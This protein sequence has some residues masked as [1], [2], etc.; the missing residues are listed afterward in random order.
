MRRAGNNPTDV[1][2]SDIVNRWQ[3]RYLKG[4]KMGKVSTLILLV[5][6][7]FEGSK[8]LSFDHSSVTYRIDPICLSTNPFW[9]YAQ[10]EQASD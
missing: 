2:V 10:K 4:D 1:E 7:K 6:G 3:S 8:T 5:K 9:N